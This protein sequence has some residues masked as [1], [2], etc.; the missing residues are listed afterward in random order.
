MKVSFK[1]LDKLCRLGNKDGRVSS[2]STQL[3]TYGFMDTGRLVFHK[4]NSI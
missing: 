1:P 4:V 3:D 2:F